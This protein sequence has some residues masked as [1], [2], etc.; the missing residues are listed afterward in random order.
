MTE[1]RLAEMQQQL[2]ALQRVNEQLRQAQ[3]NQA[4]AQDGAD[5]EQPRIDSYRAPKLP[6]FYKRDPV[7]WFAQVEA[8][9]RNAKI[10]GQDTK[11]DTVIAV[12]DADAAAVISDLILAPDPNR[13]YDNLKERMIVAFSASAETK[14]RQLLKG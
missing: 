1:E 13:P 8:L 7:L 5:A 3:N 10:T 4:L 9:F 14:L 6:A 2:D 11:A 12:L